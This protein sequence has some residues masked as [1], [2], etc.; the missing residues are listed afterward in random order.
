MSRNNSSGGSGCLGFLIIGVVAVLFLVYI[1]GP[2]LLVSAAVAVMISIAIAMRIPVR[3]LLGKSMTKP[4]I[5]TP[6]AVHAGEIL[7]VKPAGPAEF[8]PWDRAWPNYFPHQF[9]KDVRSM[10]REASREVEVMGERLD[11]MSLPSGFFGGIA[12]ILVTI[13]T[14][15][16]MLIVRAAT[17]GV[18][19]VMSVFG[20]LI[21]LVMTFRSSR[22]KRR[23]TKDRAKI[24]ADIECLSCYREI[25]LPVYK[26]PTC[27]EF[28]TDISPGPLGLQQRIC[29]CGTVLPVGVL[30]SSEML[31][32]FCPHCD[33]PLAAGSGSRRLATVPVFGTI[34]A[35]KSTFIHTLAARLA[36]EVPHLKV[37]ALYETS[38]VFLSQAITHKQEGTVPAKTPVHNRPEG[39]SLLV[40]HADEDV[41]VHF[42]DAAGELF[43]DVETSATLSYLDNART[44]LLILDPLSIEDI[45]VQITDTDAARHRASDQAPAIAYGSVIDRLRDA[46][47]DLGSRRLGIVVSKA[48]AVNQIFPS[49]QVGAT[50]AEVRSWL[51]TNG[52]DDLVRRS[53]IDFEAGVTYFAVDSLSPTAGNEEFSP[54]NILEWV[55]SASGGTLGLA[56]NILPANQ[57]SASAVQLP[58]P[59]VEEK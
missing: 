13:F 27:T 10:N 16:F 52:A 56:Q 32:S 15:A 18:I 45:R 12:T 50:S 58:H 53:E 4:D 24:A 20:W 29:H 8:L 42:L 19:A 2:L 1:V 51:L 40:T 3:V 36:T 55:V 57:D 14:L 44:L 17:F 11:G 5:A 38:E 54:L 31:E 49:N 47:V 25:E 41:E 35:G 46:S 34:S 59:T 39:A 48:D 22:I 37:R 26:C 28:H 30:R 9:H 21:G 7:G 43:R 23:E 33:K 6:D